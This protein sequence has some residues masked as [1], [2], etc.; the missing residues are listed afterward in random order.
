MS[1]LLINLAL[2]LLVVLW[3]WLEHHRFTVGLAL[4]GGWVLILIAWVTTSGL[5]P[6]VARELR[7]LVRKEQR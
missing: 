4:V 3:H 5:I 6:T 2:H 7:A 1:E